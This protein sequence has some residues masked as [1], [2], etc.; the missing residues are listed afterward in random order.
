MK[1]SAVTSSSLEDLPLEHSTH[2]AS[3]MAPVWG[4][5]LPAPHGVH[6]PVPG[7]SAYVPMGQAPQNVPPLALVDPTGQ[8]VNGGENEVGSPR[9]APWTSS[10]SPA[11]LDV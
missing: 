10:C 8:G 5:Y 4:L 1:Q 9:T 6:G 7:A 2:A 11:E 3:E